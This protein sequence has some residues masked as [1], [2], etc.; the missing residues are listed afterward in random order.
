MDRDKH[1][2]QGNEGS[3]PYAS[4]RAALALSDAIQE[5]SDQ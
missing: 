3:Y 2:N 1:Q 4:S 5:R